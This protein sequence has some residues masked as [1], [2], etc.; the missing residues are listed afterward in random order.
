[1]NAL[2]GGY[3]FQSLSWLLKTVEQISVKF[4]VGHPQEKM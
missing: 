4:G 2:W 1:M 3:V